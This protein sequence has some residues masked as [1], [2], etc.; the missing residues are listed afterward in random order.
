MQLNATNKSCDDQ[1]NIDPNVKLT[2]EFLSAAMLKKKEVPSKNR[3]EIKLG[4]ISYY[5]RRTSQLKLLHPKNKVAKVCGKG[6][7]KCV[8]TH[9]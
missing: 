9:F 5:R 8:T 2:S 7:K 3:G 6:E 1:E 4:L